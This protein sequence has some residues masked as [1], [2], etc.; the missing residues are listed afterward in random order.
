MPTR[1]LELELEVEVEDPMPLILE[2]I[3]EA[4]L[5]Q[6]TIAPDLSAVR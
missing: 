1:L 6:T 4:L 2:T 5:A 3:R